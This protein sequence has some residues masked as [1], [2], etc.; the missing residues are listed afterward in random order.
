MNGENNSRR[1]TIPMTA[2]N[3][4]YD[5]WIGELSETPNRCIA[6]GPK[7]LLRQIKTPAKKKYKACSA[8]KNVG[9]ETTINND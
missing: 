9:K 1:I 7:T 6:I 4:G 5:P 8:E 2:A 3:K